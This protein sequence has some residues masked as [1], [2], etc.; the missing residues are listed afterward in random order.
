MQVDLPLQ[1]GWKNCLKPLGCVM[2]PNRGR[3]SWRWAPERLFSWL[4]WELQAL[5]AKA[6]EFRAF[7]RKTG[8]AALFKVP[9]GAQSHTCSALP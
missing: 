3:E 7:K 1:S 9:W 8:N 4:S 2:F 5:E 6:K